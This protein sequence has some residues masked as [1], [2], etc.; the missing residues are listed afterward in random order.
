MF[1]LVGDVS[2]CWCV[3]RVGVRL[4]CVINAVDIDSSKRGGSSG[5]AVVVVVMAEVLQR[6]VVAVALA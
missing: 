1:V 6:L 3:V 5:G 4:W 2:V